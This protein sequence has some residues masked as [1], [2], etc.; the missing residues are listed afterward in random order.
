MAAA[1]TAS[2]TDVQHLHTAVTVARRARE[3]GNHPFG[4]VLAGPDGTILLE[5]E[6][7]VTTERDATGHAETNLVRLSTAAYDAAF[8]RTCTLY[9]STEPC[10]MCSGAIYWS[11]IGRVVYALGEDQLLAMTGADPENP[12][13]A[14]PCRDVFAA[15][16]RD[17]PVVGPVDM[18]GARAVHEGFWG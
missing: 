6:N 8:L 16:Q 4:A 17:L 14:L 3:A 13:M 7:T 9:T 15:G 2:A 1:Q 5:A 18:D 10:A 12:T 11:G